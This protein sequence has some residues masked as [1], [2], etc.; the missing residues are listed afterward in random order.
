MEKHLA[1]FKDNRVIPVV[2]VNHESEILPVMES[3]LEGGLNSM[4]IVLRTDAALKA[5]KQAS[6]SRDFLVGAG[7][8]LSVDQA[9]AVIDAGARFVVTPGFN[10]DVVRKCLDRKVPVIP[11]VATPTDINRALDF[12]VKVLKF[13]P[14]EAFGGVKAIK[15]ISAPFPMIDFIPT[16][17]ISLK[18]LADYLSFK[19]IIAC[20]GTW[21]VKPEWIKAREFGRIVEVARETVELVK[22]L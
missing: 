14:A 2:S 16:G 10:P 22:H 17:G 3:L 19:K 7:T 12:G 9:E 4:E 21:M 11:G 13:F 18:N 20:G 8:V 5:I 6:P 1:L 15:A